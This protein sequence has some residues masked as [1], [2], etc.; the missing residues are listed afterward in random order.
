VGALVVLASVAGA[1]APVAGQ[2]PAA[3]A[4]A[5]L[6]MAPVYRTDGVEGRMV[7]DASSEV[8]KAQIWDLQVVGHTIYAAG[9]FTKVVRASGTWPRVDQPFLAAFDTVT[10]Q[11]VSTWRP[12]VNRPV[13]A[14]DVLPSGSIVAAGEFTVANNLPAHGIVALNPITGTTDLRFGAG[15]QRIPDSHFAV[16]RDLDVRGT[17]VYAVGNFN[18]AHGLVGSPIVVAKAVRFSTTTGTPDPTWIPRL[19]GASAFAVAVS[20]DGRRVHLGGGFSSVNG[21]RGTSQLATVTAP[22]GALVPGWDNGSNVAQ[23]PVWPVGGMVF[24]LDVYK[25]SL[26]VAGAEHFWERRSSV[27]GASLHIQHISND[28]QTVEVVGNRVYIGCHCYK[29]DPNHQLW[30]VDASTG[31]ALRGRTGALQSGDGTWATAVAPDGCTWLGGDFNVAFN[32][33][34]RGRGEYWVGRIARLCPSGGPQAAPAAE[35]R[36]GPINPPG[37]TPPPR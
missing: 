23:F 31:R 16:I 34:G 14:L 37:W 35:E 25:R 33:A 24:D 32:L 22:S 1:T 3:E 30:E 26:Y 18:R 12:R 19:A 28:G 27:T 5:A 29:R 9:V 17:R 15:V 8:S 7:T 13:Y 36:P 10:G 11:W 6:N 20:A 4:D 21:R 2:P